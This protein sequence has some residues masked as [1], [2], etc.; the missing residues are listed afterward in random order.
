MAAPAQL[1]P[2]TVDLLILTAVSR[3][4]FHGYG[5]AIGALLEHP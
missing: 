5:F 1:L 2:G 4:P 3:G